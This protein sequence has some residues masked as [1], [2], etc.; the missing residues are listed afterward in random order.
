MQQIVLFIYLFSPLVNVNTLKLL[1]IMYNLFFS[2]FVSSIYNAL[3]C[4][5]QF[6]SIQ[7]NSQTF[8]VEIAP[9]TSTSQFGLLHL[10]QEGCLQLSL[11]DSEFQANTMLK[12]LWCSSTAPSS[13]APSTQAKQ[14][15]A[16]SAIAKKQDEE[17]VVRGDVHGD[18]AQEPAP[19]RSY[20]CALV[21]RGAITAPSVVSRVLDGIDLELSSLPK[22]QETV[23]RLVE[24]A[25]NAYQVRKFFKGVEEVRGVLQAAL[26]GL[27][28][29]STRQAATSKAIIKELLTLTD[30]D[31]SH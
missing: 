17:G 18:T 2:V 22:S 5:L 8:V 3:Q 20:H 26:D 31:Q 7:A 16:A 10:G 21:S 9:G 23:R 25:V 1:F 30:P 28:E 29:S 4:L 27:K 12:A 14:S 15:V 13:A 19:K 6:S 11:L 24:S